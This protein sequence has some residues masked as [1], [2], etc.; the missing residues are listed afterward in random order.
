MGDKSI[1]KQRIHESD[2]KNI[3]LLQSIFGEKSLDEFWISVNK[4]YAAISSKEIRVKLPFASSWFCEVGFSALTEIKSKK[5]ET[6]FVD[7]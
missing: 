6:L 5:R 4:L 3:R 2:I 1:W 7:I